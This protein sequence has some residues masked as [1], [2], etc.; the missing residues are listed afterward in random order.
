MVELAVLRAIEL[1]LPRD[2]PV[3]AFFDL[4]VG[5]RYVEMYPLVSSFLV[6][7]N[8]FLI[9]NRSTGGIIAL[10]LGAEH[11]TIEECLDKFV[12]L[13]TKAFTAHKTGPL[14]LL[15]HG[16]RYKTTHLQQAIQAVFSGHVLFGGHFFGA[17][18]SSENP[19]KLAVTSTTES[20][21]QAVV[22]TNYNR[23]IEQDTTYKFERP[24]EPSKELNIWEV[25]RATSAAPTYFKPFVN[26]WTKQG[27]LDG[28]IYH[29]WSP[30][31]F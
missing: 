19:V 6:S 28:A 13:C 1:A 17:R 18:L 30:D 5:T 3:R 8:N 27:Y 15:H 4:I 23:N 16:G 11:W 14:A 9:A 20:W 10:G 7:V 25:A 26:H 12:N 24:E 21:E 2:I 22:F 31:C 29:V